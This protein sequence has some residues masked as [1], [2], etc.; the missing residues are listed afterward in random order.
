MGLRARP[1]LGSFGAAVSRASP[2]SDQVVPER[3]SLMNRNLRLT[4]KKCKKPLQKVSIAGPAP[5]KS[6]CSESKAAA[7]RGF[8]AGDA[9]T[10]RLIE[11]RI[12]M[13]LSQDSRKILRG[14]K[15][16]FRTS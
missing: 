6:Q 8:N 1:E 12:A 4:K 10:T 13:P 5:P 3:Y 16:T 11:R 15:Q 7:T 2:C 9:I 14:V